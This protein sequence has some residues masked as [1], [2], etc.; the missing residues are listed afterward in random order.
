MSDCYHVQLLEG[1]LT[2]KILILL[3]IIVH[4]QFSEVPDRWPPDQGEVIYKKCV[5][6][7]E[8]LGYTRPLGTEY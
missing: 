1:D 3:N 2:H 8:D 6:V 7:I 5:G 4:T